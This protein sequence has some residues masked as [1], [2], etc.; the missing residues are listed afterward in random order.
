MG[1]RFLIK[2]ECVKER[3]QEAEKVIVSFSLSHSVF[4]TFTYIYEGVSER[5]EASTRICLESLQC[6]KTRLTLTVKY[7]AR[8]YSGL[9]CGG[10]LGSLLAEV[11]EGQS[12][13]CLF[14]HGHPQVQTQP[15]STA[16]T[17][18]MSHSYVDRHSSYTPPPLP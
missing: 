10:S 1:R 16:V 14:S 2:P 3:E 13:M 18:S 15:V 17:Y 6:S 7:N 5:E 8:K 4:L 11:R 12:S 9:C